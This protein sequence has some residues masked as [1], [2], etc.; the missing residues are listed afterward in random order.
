MPPSLSCIST[1]L[2]SQAS[3]PES[4]RILSNYRNAAGVPYGEIRMGA[5]FELDL[6]PSLSPSLL[7]IPPM[8]EGRREGQWRAD[9]LRLV[10]LEREK[11]VRAV[12]MLPG[13]QRRLLGTDCSGECSLICTWQPCRAPGRK[14]VEG[15]R[16]NCSWGHEIVSP[17]TCLFIA[18]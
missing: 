12:M 2:D 3:R 18:V 1:S 15:D 8:M 6:S 13:V 10:T 11:A 17:S 4:F 5:P 9:L 16:G 14:E 7:R